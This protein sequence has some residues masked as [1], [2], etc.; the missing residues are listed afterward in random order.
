MGHFPGRLPVPKV[1]RELRVL[2]LPPNEV[3]SQLQFCRANTDVYTTDFYAWCLST[4]ALVREGQW[5]EIDS[6]ALAAE[7]DDEDA[8]EDEDDEDDEDEDDEDDE[9][10]A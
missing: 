6:E 8:D 7:P 10:D 1:K 3:L 4:A 5:D 2:A 9:D